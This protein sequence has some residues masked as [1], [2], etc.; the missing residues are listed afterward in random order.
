MN[1]APRTWDE[2]FIWRAPLPVRTLWLLGFVAL[3]T[4]VPMLCDRRAYDSLYVP[5]LY[6]RDWARLLREIGWYPTWVIAACALWLAERG[7][8]GRADPGGTPADAGV[9][10]S[11]GRITAAWTA[12]WRATFLLVA[13]AVSGI[14]CEVLKL[15]IRRERPEL[16]DGAY[17]FRP[18]SD[19]PFSSAG[20]ATPSSHTMVAFAAA[21]A[22]ARLFPGAR[23]V[24]YAL[25]AGCAVTR[26]MARAHFVSDV[27][28]GALLGWSVGW[29]V[30][31]AMH[32]RAS[33]GTTPRS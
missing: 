29:G 12:G 7:R 1:G 25:A 20:L 30:W 19:E 16:N 5:H 14:V 28:L 17:G 10:A 18:W 13:P 4:F 23:P 15:A 32:R 6:D 33:G 8:V 11:A 21:T 22:L 24:W 2:R 26:V 27:T 3:V 31:I 9:L